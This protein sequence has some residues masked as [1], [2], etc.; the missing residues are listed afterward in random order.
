MS[1]CRL[2]SHFQHIGHR[3]VVSGQI[4]FPRGDER[5]WDADAGVGSREMLSGDVE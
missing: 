1:L 5:D 2:P 3:R 4:G